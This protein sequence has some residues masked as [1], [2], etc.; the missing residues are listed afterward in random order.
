M[1]RTKLTSRKALGGKAPRRQ[2]MTAAARRSVAQTGAYGGVK[3]PR[4][5]RPGTV[6]LRQIRRYQKSAD[7]LLRKLPFQRL[8]REI[9]QDF[10]TDLRF[11]SA[12]ISALQEACEA[13]M[14]GLFEDANL[15]AIHSKR[16]T[17]MPRDLQLARR[18]GG[19]M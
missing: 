10:A 18:I 9:A 2:L 17:I 11:Q 14:V 5:W 3:K 15:C 12:A 1:A 13:Y 19:R 4:R 16:V 7:M 8:I 6:A